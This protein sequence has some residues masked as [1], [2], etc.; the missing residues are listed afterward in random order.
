MLLSR[1]PF[2]GV[3]VVCVGCAC[4]LASWWGPITF[5]SLTPAEQVL[6]IKEEIQWIRGVQ[7]EVAEAQRKQ[8][9]VRQR[10][11]HSESVENADVVLHSEPVVIHDDSHRSIEVR[12]YCLL[13]LCT[14]RRLS[15]DELGKLLEDALAVVGMTSAE[16][17]SMWFIAQTPSNEI[18]LEIQVLGME[19]GQTK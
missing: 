11:E 10:I 16:P 5:E 13:R 17:P 15:E 7:A 18:G 6:R 3:A 19:I 12:H 2:L 1:I 4:P 9:L 8:D 14:T